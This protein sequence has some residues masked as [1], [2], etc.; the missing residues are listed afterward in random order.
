MERF[1]FENQGT[2]T[3]LV[4]N[5]TG[6]EIDSM[7]LGM[8]T[9]NKIPGFAPAL[10][11]QQDEE[12]L[13]K[14]NISSQITLRQYFSGAVSKK[15]L[16][17][18][19]SGILTALNS[20]EE[21]ML[22]LNAVLLNPD[23]IFVDVTSCGVKMIC[24]PAL[25][26]PDR[27]YDYGTFFKQIM[28]STQFDQTED[29]EHVTR[30]IHYL[31]GAGAFSV[32]EFARLI[33]DLDNQT[34]QLTES[35]KA[36]A[37][38]QWRSETTLLRTEE[39]A[40]G[41]QERPAQQKT[42]LFPN[43]MAQQAQTMPPVS[44][45]PPGASA[46]GGVMQKPEEK[47]EKNMSLFYLMRHYNKE[48]ASEYKMRKAD[49]K[50]AEKED[51]E[52]KKMEKRQQKQ[53]KKGKG[54]QNAAKTGAQPGGMAVP[55][56][57]G[58][59]PGGM[60]IPSGTN[61]QPAGMAIPAGT[62]VQPG[63][64]A[65]PP[66][67]GMQ[68]GGM[69]IPAGTGVQ[70]GNMAAPS[71]TGIQP[72]GMTAPVSVGMQ[73]NGMASSLS[74]KTAQPHGITPPQPYGGYASGGGSSDNFGETTVLVSQTAGETTVLKST[75]QPGAA[76]PYLLR[77]RNGEKISLNRPVFRIG[78]ERSFVDYLI[79]DNTAVSRSH[80]NFIRKDGACFVVDT[81]STNH[82]YINGSMIPSNV[83]TALH[84]GDKVCLAN[85][86]FQFHQT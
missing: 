28:F 20:A 30:I 36:P 68:P 85:E 46:M 21:Y 60:A 11:T 3:Y 9:N 79:S 78:K 62:G 13:M 47:N 29:C 70:P 15:R 23:Y 69:A 59:Q 49:R 25:H 32:E 74:G 8:L 67:M 57:T 26:M 12:M 76:Q 6:Q 7:S 39:H 75:A 40:G 65:V 31:N 42:E 33:R 55:A 45:L 56:G 14:Y 53:E 86:E 80:A 38:N 84:D 10:Y 83:E 2:T 34:R 16:L 37:T 43:G 18:V 61:I 22:D 64:M 71:R 58:V 4:C 35:G 51:K 52:R 63:N 24:V 44:S 5:L 77:S 66:G 81:N 27:G 72:G 1:R 17:G 48:N 54:K 41:M 73:R 19:I 50:Q 82:T